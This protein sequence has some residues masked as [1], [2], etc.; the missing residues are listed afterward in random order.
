MKLHFRTRRCLIVVLSTLAVYPLGRGAISQAQTQTTTPLDNGGRAVGVAAAPTAAADDGTLDF[1]TPDFNLKLAKSSQV[2]AAL[3]PKGA[4]GM[5]DAPFDFTPA[6]QR[7]AR[8]GNRFNHL[9]DVAVRARVLGDGAP[10]EWK[11]AATSDLRKPVAPVTEV[12]GVTPEGKILAAADLSPTLPQDFPL[13]ITRCW[14]VDS[15]GRLV[16]H[17]QI[18]NKSESPVEIG[19]LGFPLVFNNMIQDFNTNQPRTLPQAHEICSFFDPYVGQDA[20]YLQVTRL[21]GAGPALAV[22][23]ETGTKTPF[24]AYRPL[25]DASPKSQ[26]FEGACEWTV[27]SKAY[28]ENEWKGVQQWNPGTSEI[29]QPGE[30]VGHGLRFVVADSI[31]NIEKSLADADRPVAVGIP[32]YVLPMDIDAKL[33]IKPGSR[34]IS[35]IESEPKDAIVAEVGSPTPSGWQQYTLHGKTWGR[36]RLTITYD[37]GDKQAIHYYVIKPEAEAV[38]DLGNFLFTKQWYTDESDPFHR[39]PSIMTYDR[40][41]DRI[42]TQDSRVWIAGLE[43]EGGAGSWIAAAMKEFGQPNKDELDKFE[44]FIDKVLWGRIQFSEGPRKYGVRKS[45][46]YYDPKELPDFKYDADFKWL[47]RNPQGEMVPPWTAWNKQG[48]EDTGRA[49]NYPHVAAAYWTMYRLARNNDGLV[50]AH[51]WQWYLD[52]AFNTVKFLTGGFNQGDNPQDVGYLD[53]GLMEGDIFVLLLQD[54]KRENW[55]EQANYVEG[56]MKRRAEHWNSKAYPFGSEMAWDSTGQEEVYAWTNYFDYKDKARVS[57]DSILGYMPT[58]P[59]WGYNGNAR[60]YWDFYYGA[61]PGGTTER[62]LHHYGS[63]INAI[64]VLGAVSRTSGRF[65]SAAHRLR[66][67]D[68]GDFE[69]RPR[70]FC[71]HGFPQLPSTF[72]LGHVLRRLWT[73][74]S[75]PRLDDGYV[76][77]QS[78]GVRLAG[79]WRKSEG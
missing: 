69:H 45:L 41:H 19:G 22:V 70:G 3:E 7:K 76:C 44:L 75:R 31:R 12:K 52:H 60:R 64:P 50:T 25:N 13:Q 57:L 9:G 73:E 78:P 71:R 35:S 4:K 21:S 16:L 33:F 51:P 10:G 38:A 20:G 56:A 1:D 14:F 23:P 24:E 5:G 72:A 40:G 39:A 65:L 55:T 42:V 43:D 32:G 62:Q 37:N 77:R 27:R 46:F 11:N 48:A 8:S 79:V 28:A 63:G 36:A 2:I 58:L 67:H 17:F 53:T 29:L 66:R 15:S 54:L 61:A 26:T 34:K 30:T 68:G 6:D 49:Y 18:T 74:L 59:H 47:E